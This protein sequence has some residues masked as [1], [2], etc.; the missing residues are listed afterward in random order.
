MIDLFPEEVMIRLRERFGKAYELLS[1]PERV[2][3]AL[4][5][6]IGTVNHARL[7]SITTQHSFDLSKTLQHLTQAGMLQS[8]GGVP[9]RQWARATLASA[10]A[11][12]HDA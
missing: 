9:Q 6:S 5:A 12:I 3:L 4:A 2:A 10:N 7:R 8:I 11:H 1:Y